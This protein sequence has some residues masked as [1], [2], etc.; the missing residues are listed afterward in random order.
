M[1]LSLEGRERLRK[2]CSLTSHHTRIPEL[3]PLESRHQTARVTMSFQA[4]ILVIDVN[5]PPKSLLS[6]MNVNEG[7]SFLFDLLSRVVDPDGIT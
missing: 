2:E 3:K 1:V 5:R 4:E 6:D 7:E